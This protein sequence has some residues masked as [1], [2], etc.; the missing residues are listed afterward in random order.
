MVPSFADL[1]AVTVDAFGT[2]VRLRDPVPGLQRELSLRGVERTA[3]EIAEGFAAEGE[4]YRA[5]K[6]CARD[7]AALAALQRECVAVF[8][9]ALAAPIAPAD[10][11]PA[12]L[13]ALEFEPIPGTR[14][15]LAF[16]RARGLALAVVSDWDL[17]ARAELTRHGIDV[18]VDT[19]V[20]SAE[21]GV[22]KP[23]PRPFAAALE[24]LGVAPARALHVGDGPA[25]E[26]GAAAAGLHFAPA[27]LAGLA[28][29]A[30]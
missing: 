19:I 13:A 6:A 28:E 22:E 27:P 7:E 21:L 3:G 23:D 11:T 30:R 9:S 25:D 14:E 12:Y 8:L 20:I 26:Q 2:L 29:R 1:D 10:F 5:H 15:A 17:S 24:R 16:L 4:H 18:L